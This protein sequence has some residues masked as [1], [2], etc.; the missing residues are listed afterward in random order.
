MTYTPDGKDAI[1]I[2]QTER[3]VAGASLSAVSHRIVRQPP[4]LPKQPLP[5]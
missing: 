1:V 2:S 5:R 4:P 3:V